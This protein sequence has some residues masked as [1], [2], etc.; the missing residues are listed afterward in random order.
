MNQQMMALRNYDRNGIWNFFFPYMI[1]N[2]YKKHVIFEHELSNMMVDVVL[3]ERKCMFP[4]RVF[5][6]DTSKTGIW[7]TLCLSLQCFSWK[8]REIPLPLSARLWPTT[9]GNGIWE[10]MMPGTFLAIT[11]ETQGE[12]VEGQYYNHTCSS[13]KN[14][15]NFL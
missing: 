3:C 1:G 13:T 10:P 7:R 4:T 2:V 8:M 14:N 6:Y 12:V 9:Q 5:E 15:H 11:Q